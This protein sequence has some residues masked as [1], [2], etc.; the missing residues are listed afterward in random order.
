VKILRVFRLLKLTKV[1]KFSIYI[2]K[3]EDFLHVPPAVFDLLKLGLQVYVICHLVA[4]VWW[5]GCTVF[6]KYTWYDDM[7]IENSSAGNQYIVALY[8]TVATITSVGYGDIVPVNT[9]ERILNI[10]IV[11][12]GASIF[13]FMIANVTSVMDGFNKVRT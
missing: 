2:E 10:I 7:G 11:L 13:G 8:W 3:M 12:F 9:S 6:S 1:L 4:C 5:G